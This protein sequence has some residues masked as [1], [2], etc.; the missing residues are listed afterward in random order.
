MS[1]PRKSDAWSGM[2][3]GWAITS[4]LV[5]G[6]VT[7]GALGYLLDRIFRSG[8]G[9]TALGIV[10]GAALAIYIVY[11]RYGKGGE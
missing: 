8:S 1:G 7:V 11:L 2:G 9:F 5:G 4:H 10:L 6:M 3:I